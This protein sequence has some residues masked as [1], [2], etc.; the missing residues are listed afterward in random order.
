MPPQFLGTAVVVAAL[1]LAGWCLVPALRDRTVGRSH[2]V[3][4]GA[5][6]ALVVAEVIAAI[7]HLVRGEHPRETVTFLGYLVAFL[8]ILPVAAILARLEPT[9]W[10]AV[11]LTVAALVLPVLILRINQLWLSRA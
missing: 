2:W 6:Q 11:I 8:A 5:V 10:G 7:V 9:R 1:L 4:L 3:A